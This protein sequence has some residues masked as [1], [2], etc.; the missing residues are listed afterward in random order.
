M[1]THTQ[2]GLF[3]QGAHVPDGKAG[4]GSAMCEQ[5]ELPAKKLSNLCF[6]PA[7]IKLL[8]GTFMTI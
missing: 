1:S 3:E 7:M 8:N 2:R 4:V 5:Q 6:L